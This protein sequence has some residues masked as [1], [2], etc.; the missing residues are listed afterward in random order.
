MTV[1]LVVVLIVFCVFIHV[2][3][4]RIVNA[5]VEARRS[6]EQTTYAVWTATSQQTQDLKR[7]DG[8]QI[9]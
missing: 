1:E 2:E 5:V 6:V 8:W 3:V 9:G 7:K 4:G